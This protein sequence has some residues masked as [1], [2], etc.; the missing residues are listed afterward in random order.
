LLKVFLIIFGGLLPPFSR[1]SGGLEDLL[2]GGGAFLGDPPLVAE[3]M[4]ALIG[5]FLGVVVLV[6]GLGGSS[7]S[8]DRL[9]AAGE[10]ALDLA[11][12]IQSLPGGQWLLGC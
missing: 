3:S 5:D 10:W 11:H 12:Q 9:L 1:R 6:G 8:G 4:R 7:G 2:G